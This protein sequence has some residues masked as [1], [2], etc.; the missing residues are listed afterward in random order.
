MDGAA[1]G[2]SDGVNHVAQLWPILLPD[3]LKIILAHGHGFSILAHRPLG[4]AFHP[5]VR[6]FGH[7]SLFHVG[8]YDEARF[9][10]A[11]EGPSNGHGLVIGGIVFPPKPDPKTSLQEVQSNAKKSESDIEPS[12]AITPVAL[13]S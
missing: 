1:N 11:V 10:G 3:G 13:A 4:E 5:V 8:N 7:R 9:H 12:F 6:P 2:A